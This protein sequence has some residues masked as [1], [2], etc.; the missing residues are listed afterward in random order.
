MSKPRDFERIGQ[1]LRYLEAHRLQQP[2][3]EQVAAHVQLS[4]SHFQRLFGRW[5]GVSPKRFLQFLTLDSARR[6]LA[7]ARPVLDAT[8]DAGL[9]SPSRLHDLFVSIE[10]VT[11]GEYKACG[12]GLTI[13][14]GV[15]RSPFGGCLIGSTERGVC[16]LSFHDQ[17][18]ASGVDQLAQTWQRARLHRDQTNAAAWRDRIFG[19]PAGNGPRPLPLL[20]RGT[21]FQLKVWEALIRIPPGRVC[22]YQDLAR[23]IGRP[24]ATRAVASAVAS[25]P[26]SFLIPC[27]RVIRSMGHF[28]QYRWGAFRKKA[29]IGWEMTAAA[30]VSRARPSE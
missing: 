1:A 7:E 14:Y 9:S 26:V 12:E 21:N 27:H 24:T 29:L 25:N 17:D 15:Q 23:W 19:G 2:S 11:P 28:G 10:A 22:A 6:A 16:W 5:V 13:R 20:V 4:P 8:F 18:E 3:L 30:G